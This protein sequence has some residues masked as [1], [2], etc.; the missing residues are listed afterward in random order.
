MNSRRED[1]TKDEKDEMHQIMT[2]VEPL[3]EASEY[4]TWS[5]ILMSHGEHAY[6]CL[7]QTLW[8]TKRVNLMSEWDVDKIFSTG[9]PD[10][11]QQLLILV[12][13]AMMVVRR[14]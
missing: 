11:I 6:H 12:I 1:P 5:N 3:L 10:Q 9:L 13:S 8:Y 2:E 7:A 4:R 14:F